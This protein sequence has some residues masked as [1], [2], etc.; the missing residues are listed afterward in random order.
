MRL[1]GTRSEARIKL[2]VFIVGQVGRGNDGELSQLDMENMY[3]I[4][5]WSCK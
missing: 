2:L 5:V 3:P 1:E 4:C